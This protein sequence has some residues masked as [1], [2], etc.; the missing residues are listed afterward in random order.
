MEISSTGTLKIKGQLAAMSSN[1][2][3]GTPEEFDLTHLKPTKDDRRD[4]DDSCC[5]FWNW[6]L[7][8]LS[9]FSFLFSSDV[10]SL[11]GSSCAVVWKIWHLGY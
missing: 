2:R 7:C 9:L 1:G 3:S 10:H 6:C 4:K 8:C 5:F 11:L